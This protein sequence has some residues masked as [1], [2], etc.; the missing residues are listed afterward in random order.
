MADE[1]RGGEIQ[2]SREQ[3]DTVFL[4]GNRDDAPRYILV[5]PMWNRIL[6]VFGCCFGIYFGVLVL[7]FE[8]PA[9][10]SRYLPLTLGI[11]IPA[12]L[13]CLKLRGRR[14][15][16]SG[17]DN[18]GV[19]GEVGEGADQYITVCPMTLFNQILLVLATCFFM[20]P[21]AVVISSTSNI[22]SSPERCF[23]FILGI[24]MLM[25]VTSVKLRRQQSYFLTVKMIFSLMKIVVVGVLARAIMS[26]LP[27]GIAESMGCFVIMEIAGPK[28]KRKTLLWTIYLSLHILSFIYPGEILLGN[29]FFYKLASALELVTR[30]IDDY[31]AEKEGAAPVVKIGRGVMDLFSTVFILVP[32]LGCVC[33]YMSQMRIFQ[34]MGV[35]V[36][37]ETFAEK[38][39][40]T[41]C[42]LLRMMNSQKR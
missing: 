7:A 13:A 35:D 32:V 10:L 12:M 20:G 30:W 8:K 25:T 5:C 37:F 22:Q 26:G 18:T 23:L 41:C 11:G 24:G 29:I 21:E 2:I 34:E 19:S 28:A 33:G 17:G 27:D 14:L 16:L 4:N 36:L 15:H 3:D 42:W 38:V 1:N 39:S 40:A 6:L 9:D 31:C